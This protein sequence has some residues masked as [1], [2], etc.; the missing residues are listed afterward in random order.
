LGFTLGIAVSRVLHTLW[1]LNRERKAM[2]A[3]VLKAADS[4]STDNNAQ[5][6]RSK[7]G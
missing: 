3:G 1:M 6:V 2:L 7:A 4:A 5:V